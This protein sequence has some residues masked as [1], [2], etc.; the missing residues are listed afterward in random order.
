M[1]PIQIV[2]NNLWY[3]DINIIDFLRT[4]GR[5]FRMGK[6]LSRDSVQARLAAGDT[7]DGGK[8]NPD[9]GLS[10]T[11]FTYQVFQAYDWF[12]LRHNYDCSIQLGGSDQMGNIA[13]GHEFISKFGSSPDRFTLIKQRKDKMESE[14]LKNSDLPAYGVL[15]PLLTSESGEKFGKSQKGRL[16][17][18]Q[19]RI[20]L[21]PHKTTPFEFYQFF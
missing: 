7:K 2:N 9:G 20:W 6:L 14:T 3:K 4:A 11:E 17:P 16:R 15:L 18:S 12:H 19:S 1:T 13:T 10:F 8:A 21:S 5:K